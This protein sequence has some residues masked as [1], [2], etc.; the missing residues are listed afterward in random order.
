MKYGFAHLSFKWT[1]NAKGNAGVTVIILGLRNINSQPKYLFNGNIRKEA[2]NIN[3]Y[4]LDGANVVIAERALPISDFPQMKK[5]I[6][7]MT[8]VH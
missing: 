7:R 5:V 3:A 6:C 8:E 2:K 1:N 4:L